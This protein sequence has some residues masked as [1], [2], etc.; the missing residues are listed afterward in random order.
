VVVC[1]TVD[2]LVFEFWKPTEAFR[3]KVV[4]E[5]VFEFWKQQEQRSRLEKPDVRLCDLILGLPF[6]QD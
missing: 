5:L 4:D 6:D 1:S 3:A 2:E